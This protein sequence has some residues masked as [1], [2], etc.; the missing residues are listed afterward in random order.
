MISL[1]SFRNQLRNLFEEQ[2]TD[3]EFVIDER[4]STIL[5]IRIFLTPEVFMEVYVNG[6]TGKKSFALIKNEKRIWGYDNYRYW[7]HHPIENTDNHIPCSEPPLE[8]V[9]NELNTVLSQIRG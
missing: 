1:E 7:H 5:E 9:V 4:R 8:K 6:I 3:A 2:F